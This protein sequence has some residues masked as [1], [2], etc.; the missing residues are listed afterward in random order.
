MRQSTMV[1]YIKA[2]AQQFVVGDNGGVDVDYGRFKDLGS[3]AFG[4]V[5]KL[6]CLDTGLALKIFWAGDDDGYNSF[7]EFCKDNEG[8]KFLPK[9][10]ADFMIGRKCR[11]V[12]LKEF[13]PASEELKDLMDNYIS[14]ITGSCLSGSSHD[15]KET[16]IKNLNILREGLG[17]LFQELYNKE[18]QNYVMDFHYKNIMM[19]GDQ[20][21]VTDPL[22]YKKVK[23]VVNAV[24]FGIG[25]KTHKLNISHLDLKTFKGFGNGFLNVKKAMEEL[26]RFNKGLE[27][28]GFNDIE[29][30]AYIK[31]DFLAENFGAGPEIRKELL[32]DPIVDLQNK[33][34]ANKFIGCKNVDP[35]HN[36]P[37]WLRNERWV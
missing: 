1:K 30:W 12:I 32:A 26:G 18:G 9:I 36:K 14:P 7:V 22:A 6:R 25:S 10:Y 2:L 13:Q 11:A 28:G 15:T 3:G 23:P 34:L 31:R 24:D 29:R 35:K 21:I 5:L 37:V 8:N 20:W 16:K 27:L 33:D 4:S 19:D 17:D